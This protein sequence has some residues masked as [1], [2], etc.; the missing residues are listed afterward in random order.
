MLTDVREKMIIE[1]KIKHCPNC[2]S[3]DIIR[4]GTDYKESQKYHCHNCGGYGTLEAKPCY[5]EAEKELVLRAYQERS[6]M[7]G[8]HRIFGVVPKTLLRW[9]REALLKSPKLIDTLAPVRAEGILE[10]DELW[11]FVLKKAISSGCG[12][13]CIGVLDRWS[14]FTS[15]TVLRLVVNS[16]GRGYPKPINLVPLRVIFGTLIKKCVLKRAIIL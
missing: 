15:E 9:L 8:I 1:T 6:S 11:S 4:N 13:P 10:L 7:R 12:L 5:S 2:D 3:L 16:C 14:L